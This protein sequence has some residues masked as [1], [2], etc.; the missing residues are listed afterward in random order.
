MFELI[1]TSQSSLDAT[2]KYIFTDTRQN[3]TVEIAYIDKNDGKDIICVPSQSG[4]DMG[5][6]FCHVTGAGIKTANLDSLDLLCTTDLAMQEMPMHQDRTLLVSIMGCGEPMSNVDHLLRYIRGMQQRFWQQRPIRFA[7]ATIMPSGCEHDFLDVGHYVS[8]FDIDLKIHFS[9][10][11]TGEKI[12]DVWMPWAGGIRPSLDLLR[13]Y[14]SSTG[15]AIEIHYTPIQGVNDQPCHVE[16]LISMARDIPVKLLTFNPVPHEKYT[17][18]LHMDA[19][20]ATMDN[21]GMTVEIYTPPGRDIGASCGQFD[22]Q[23]YPVRRTQ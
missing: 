20:K 1:H 22:L 19:M 23:Y 12:R 16:A 7:L 14:R 15:R 8:R 10:H 4:C 3:K 11:F 2:R 5:C 17:P 18:S 9:M 6:R 13:W 21:A